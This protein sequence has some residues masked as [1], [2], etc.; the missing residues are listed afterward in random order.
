[1]TL[2]GFSRQIG[3]WDSG[4]FALLGTGR[5]LFD[6]VLS[7]QS[8]AVFALLPMLTAGVLTSEKERDTLGILLITRLGAGTIVLEKFLSRAIP[9]LLYLLLSLPLMGVAYSLGGVESGAVLSAGLLLVGMVLHIG[10]LGVFSSAYCRTTTQALLLTY[11]LLFLLAGPLLMALRFGIVPAGMPS[12]T[13]L[14]L[15][16]TALWVF[17]VTGLLPAFLWLMLA[18]LVLWRRAFLQPRNFGLR[19][20]RWLDGLFHRLNQNRVT[21]G[22]VVLDERVELPRFRPIAW[23]ETMKRS[24]GTVRYLVRFLLLVEGP[25]LFVILIP[26]SDA[27][28]WQSRQYLPVEIAVFAV[29]WV[30]IFA[31]LSQ[32]TA[33]IAGERARQTLDV[34]L[35]TPLSAEQ[36]VRDKFAG[37]QRLILVLLVPLGTVFLFRGWWFASI[38]NW[39]P[40]PNLPVYLLTSLG[41]AIV[42]PPLLGWLGFHAGLRFKSQVTAMTAALGIV[43]VLAGLPWAL[44]WVGVYRGDAEL[45]GLWGTLT[46]VVLPATG[47]NVSPWMDDYASSMG[48]GRFR[49]DRAWRDYL[50][51]LLLLHFAVYAG[52]WQW[53]RWTAAGQL[54]RF[55]NRCEQA[56]FADPRDIHRLRE[57]VCV[58]EGPA[59]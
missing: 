18:R 32:S 42:Y 39:W 1:V 6:Q 37:V 13:A 51:L 29:W 44:D 26:L 56:E 55:T 58:S 24:L 17:G 7:F 46:T 23:R 10:S 27:S 3:Q 38:V 47:P 40:R 48:M 52:L 36:I 57:R 5:I 45:G 25:L 14:P 11:L 19:I 33:L 4:S 9:M 43:L 2:W 34:L 20:L 53:L 28:V 15:G 35:S 54:V 21:K 31:V 30:T 49:T 12:R 50:P 59:V 8:F 41:S 16:W 22:I